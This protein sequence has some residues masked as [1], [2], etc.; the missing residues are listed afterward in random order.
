MKKPPNLRF[1]L[2]ERLGLGSEVSKVQAKIYLWKGSLC[3]KHVMIN[4][5]YST[6]SHLESIEING[7][8]L[9]LP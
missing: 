8:A 4:T 7:K 9:M 5:T 2:A 6:K 1:S 3:K